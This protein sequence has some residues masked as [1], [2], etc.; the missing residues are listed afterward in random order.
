[1]ERWGNYFLKSGE[2]FSNFWTD[3]QKT[4]SP[5]MLFIMGMGF[6]PR[7]NT[8]IET[9]YSFPTDNRRDTIFLRY[10][11]TEDEIDSAPPP[12]VKLHIDRLTAFLSAR[13]FSKPNQK[14]I[15]RRSNDDKSIT[16]ISATQLINTIEEF[17]PYS[18]II[19]DISAM[20]RNVF[21]PII[22]KALDIIDTYNTQ[23]ETKKNLHIVVTENSA[24]DNFIHDRGA[25]DEA[26]YIHGFRLKEIDKTKDQKEVWIPILGE[27]QLHQFEKILSKLNPVETCPVLPFPSENLRRGDKLIIEY[28][29]VLFNDSDFESKNIMYVDEANPFQAYR[30]VSRLINRY[31]QS[32][33][34]LDGCKL[35]ISILSSK[36]LAIGVFMAIYEKKKEGKNV[37]IMHLES[38]GHKLDEDYDG[39][40]IDVEKKNKLFEIWLAG[41]PYNE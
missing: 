41:N 12:E 36:L 23:N 11:K 33:R 39:S 21:V 22:N 6:D 35:I 34:L 16:S 13:N 32:L 5:K 18:D 24:L 3:Y 4:T 26:S 29:D 9:I 31:D 38:L 1:M 15:I 40:K 17:E 37:G 25:D 27:N 19:I 7:T 10:F 30:R 28:Q 8:A 20:P 14:N 2:D